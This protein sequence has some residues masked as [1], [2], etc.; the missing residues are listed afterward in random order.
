MVIISKNK[1]FGL[2]DNVRRPPESLVFGDLPRSV[3]T[4]RTWVN[5][6]A[7]IANGAK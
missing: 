1:F 5:V 4:L 3:L 2:D 7:M 6:A